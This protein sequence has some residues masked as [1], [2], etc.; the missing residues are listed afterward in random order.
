MKHGT[1]GDC[2][3]DGGLVSIMLLMIMTN[4]SMYNSYDPQILGKPNELPEQEWII[5]DC[6]GNWWRPNFEA[7]QVSMSSV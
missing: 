6:L 7:P 1:D 4:I 2:G 3:S 5:E